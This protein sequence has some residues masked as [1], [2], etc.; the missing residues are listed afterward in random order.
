M[1]G[2]YS[3]KKVFIT[4]HTGFKGTWLTAMLLESGAEITGFS[5]D[6]KELFKLAGFEKEIRHVR[7]D[8][9]DR[10]ALLKAV[11]ETEPELIFH[12]AAQP[13]VRTGLRE[14]VCTYEVNV[15]GTV[16]L[17]DAVRQVQSVRSV[18]N[19]TTDKVYKNTEKEEGYTEKDTLGGS[20]PYSNSKSC[21]ELVTD[22]YRKSYLNSHGVAVSTARAGNVIGGGDFSKDRIIPDCVRAAIKKEIVT[23]RNPGS[24]RPYQHV[25]D[26]LAAYLM[27]AERQYGDPCASSAYNIGPAEKDCISTRQLVTIFS[28]EWGEGFTWQERQEKASAEAG[29]LKLD[30][31]KAEKELGWS[32]VWDVRQAVRKTVEWYKRW[33]GGEN[34]ADIIK[35]QVTEFRR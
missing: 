24:I 21:S 25:L 14:P 4:G 19:V 12:L 35:R 28:E 34:P 27:I 5:C 8:V 10:Q 30:C 18:L 9:R 29:I 22:C 31:S 33:N 16:N 13:I 3:G 6:E 32:P 15:L 20:D 17:L 7:G 11:K 26:P 1:A 2:F 23:L